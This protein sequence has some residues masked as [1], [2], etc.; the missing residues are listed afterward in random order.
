M[1]NVT[2]TIVLNTNTVF[3]WKTEGVELVAMVMEGGDG[4][5]EMT[6]YGNQD[7]LR[8]LT[9]NDVEIIQD[10]WNQLQEMRKLAE[11][12]PLVKETLDCTDDF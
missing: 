6:V 9:L 12:A 11:V 5:A 10:N 3:V 4:E 8:V 2:C 7:G 1:K